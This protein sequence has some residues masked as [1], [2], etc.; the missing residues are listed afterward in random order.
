MKEELARLV[1]EQHEQ[2]KLQQKIQAEEL[3]HDTFD[4]FK[5]QM[6]EAK[7]CCGDLR[8][9]PRGPHLW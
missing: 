3:A 2:Y 6:E 4:T 1:R 5:R 9:P 7:V 8:A